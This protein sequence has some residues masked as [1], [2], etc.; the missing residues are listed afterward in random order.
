M[1]ILHHAGMPIGW[2][3]QDGKHIPT[4]ICKATGKPINPANPG[5]LY[6]SPKTGEMIVLSDEGEDAVR[7][8]PG[9]EYYT[10]ELD[11][12]SHYLFSNTAGPEGSK[13]RKETIKK[14]EI[15]RLFLNE[16]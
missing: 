7:S 15:L 13:D 16:K 14:A 9:S 3:V 4:F 11:V 2:V 8:T 12:L 10:I 5:T 6:W 1:K